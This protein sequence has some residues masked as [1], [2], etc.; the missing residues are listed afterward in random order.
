LREAA[1]GKA[2]ETPGV[3]LGDING[4]PDDPAPLSFSRLTMRFVD[5]VLQAR[6][7]VE[8]FIKKSLFA[9]R[10]AVIMGVV[11]MVSYIV[12]TA[13]SS[14][15]SETLVCALVAVGGVA[16]LV[17][18]CLTW[19]RRPVVYIVVMD[20]VALLLSVSTTFFAG[21]GL[22]GLALYLMGIFLVMRLEFSHACVIASFDITLWVVMSALRGYT[23]SISANILIFASLFVYCALTHWKL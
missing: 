13:R 11:F 9:L 1:Y 3:Q 18:T 19:I 17:L 16:F 12:L 20:G 8:F 14:P 7:F 5:P 2:T 23:T 4:T 22:F 6:F 21:D 10:L 15:S